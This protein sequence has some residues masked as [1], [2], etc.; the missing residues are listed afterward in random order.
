MSIVEVASADFALTAIPD[1]IYPHPL[2]VLLHPCSGFDTE[3]FDGCIALSR[4]D[5]KGLA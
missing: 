2:T 1:T 5:G 3:T 4:S